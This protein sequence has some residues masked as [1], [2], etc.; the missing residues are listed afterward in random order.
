MLHC[1]H[2]DV[3]LTKY[4]VSMFIKL[5]HYPVDISHITLW[6]SHTLPCGHLTHYPVDIS[7]F[8]VQVLLL[9]SYPEDSQS[10]NMLS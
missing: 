9:L 6:T 1:R 8:C 7:V 2:E 3:L 10:L 5:T 4:V